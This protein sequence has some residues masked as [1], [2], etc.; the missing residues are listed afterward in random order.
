M[1]EAVY[2]L[3]GTGNGATL[4]ALFFH[5]LRQNTE[6]KVVWRMTGAGDLSMRATGPGGAAVTPVWGP[7]SHGDSTWRKPGDEWGTGWVFPTAGCWTVHAT[8]SESGSGELAL[9]IR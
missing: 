3:Q 2:E 7:E 1:P 5:P 6:M 9:L 8:R 4:W